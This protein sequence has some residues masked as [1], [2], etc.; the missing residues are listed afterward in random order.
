[1]HFRV[2][3]RFV[4]VA[5]QV[6]ESRHVFGWFALK[7]SCCLAETDVGGHSTR[8]YGAQK[9]YEIHNRDR[10]KSFLAHTTDRTIDVYST[11]ADRRGRGSWAN[12]LRFMGRVSEVEQCC[13]G[14]LLLG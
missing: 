1:M 14:I 9:C 5:Y 11:A 13:R 12:T 6:F 2:D 3:E 10:A 8:I 7:R 4:F